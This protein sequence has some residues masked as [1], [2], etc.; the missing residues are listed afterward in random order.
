MMEKP[1]AIYTDHIINKTLC[2][3]LRRDQITYV[4]CR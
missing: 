2:Y 4:P 1:I 3:T